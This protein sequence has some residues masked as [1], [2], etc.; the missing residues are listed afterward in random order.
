MNERDALDIAQQAIWT[1]I[2]AAGPAVGAAMFVGIVIALLQALTQVQEMTLTFIPKIVVMLIVVAVTG[3]F[4]GA[5]I[6]AFTEV[7]YGRIER[8]F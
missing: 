2:V 3:S 4:M 1:I 8:G 7:L 5:H 6:F